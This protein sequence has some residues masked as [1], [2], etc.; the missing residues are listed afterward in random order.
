MWVPGRA[1]EETKV[2][3]ATGREVPELEALDRVMEKY[4]VSRNVSRG[5]LAVTRKGK[6]VLARGCTWGPSECTDT[7]PDS[8]F[9]VASLSKPVTAVAVL[10]LVEQGRLRLDEKVV[11]ILDLEPPTGGSLDPR[12]R[13]VTVRHLL[14]HLG[15]WDRKK[16][17]DPMFEDRRIGRELER[18]LPIG[19]AAII[20]FMSGQPLQNPPGETFAYSN[21]GY[22]LLGRIIEQK[23]GRDYEEYVRT[24]ILAPL[25][26]TRMHLGSSRRSQRLPGEVTYE[27]DRGSPYGDFRLE[28][29]DAHG[30]WVASAVDLVRFASSLDDPANCPVLSGDSIEVLFGLPGNI[31]PDAYRRGDRYYACGWAV[32]DFGDG[33]MNT[34]H[35]GSLPGSYAFMARW[36]SGVDCVAL[37]NRRT[38]DSDRIDALLSEAIR[39]VKV[40][41]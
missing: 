2:W 30:G 31:E 23:S 11:R 36:R 21:F 35:A 1:G 32:R 20:R 39:G 33:E 15:G 28:N 12:L 37:F 17:F 4:M 8:L 5:A 27:C 19:T 10:H 29:M 13:D 3:R 25:G 26:I 40:W 14:Q 24:A 38:P 18:E 22:C 6:L 34:W 7:R 41:P 16:S 9:R